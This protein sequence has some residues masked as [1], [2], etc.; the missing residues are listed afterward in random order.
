MARDITITMKD[1]TVREFK[2]A[3]RA[4]GSYT[5]LVTYEGGF[6]VVEDEWYRRTAIPACDVA[7]VVETPHRRW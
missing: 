5:V 1:G 7:E 6:V 3:G 2:H 4:G